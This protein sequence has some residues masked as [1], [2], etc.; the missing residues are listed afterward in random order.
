MRELVGSSADAVIAAYPR[1]DFMR[2]KEAYNALVSDIGFICPT[3]GLAR[4][5]GDAQPVFLYHYTHVMHGVLGT[6]GALHA[7]ELPFVFGNFPASYTPDADDLVVSAAMQRTWTSFARDHAPE[8]EPAWPMW[9]SASPSI[10]ILEDPS[11]IASDVRNG[12]CAELP[13]IGLVR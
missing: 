13:R 9:S 6:G 5:A 10:A 2:P 8:Y 4:A 3:L 1:T 12:R 7:A 11:D